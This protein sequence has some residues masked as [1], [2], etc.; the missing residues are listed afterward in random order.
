M[1]IRHK[2]WYVQLA[3]AQRGKLIIVLAARGRLLWPMKFAITK[4]D[5]NPRTH[6]QC[7]RTPDLIHLEMIS[8]NICNNLQLITNYQIPNTSQN[9]SK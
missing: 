4:K 1:I 5:L 2:I 6:H 7:S 9:L 8:N 3:A